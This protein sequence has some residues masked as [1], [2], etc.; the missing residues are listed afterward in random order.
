VRTAEFAAGTE[1]SAGS[2]GGGVSL[3]PIPFP[4]APAQPQVVDPPKPPAGADQVPFG[5]VQRPQ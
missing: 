3:P 2:P 4:S 5:G 1:V